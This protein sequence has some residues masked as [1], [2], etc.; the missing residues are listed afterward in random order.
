MVVAADS[1][2]PDDADS[3]GFIAPPLAMATPHF[4][5]QVRT[6]SSAYALRELPCMYA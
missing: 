2:T 6:P 4:L 1:G 3:V 5:R